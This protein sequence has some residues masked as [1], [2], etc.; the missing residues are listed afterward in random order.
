MRRGGKQ[1]AVLLAETRTGA[2]EGT[3]GI[4]CTVSAGAVVLPDDAA[5]TAQ[6]VERTEVA[7][8][9]AKRGGKNRVERHQS[10]SM[11]EPV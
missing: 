1:F 9:C 11:T 3:E 8:E 2:R 4:A 6:L 10:N 5:N 7:V